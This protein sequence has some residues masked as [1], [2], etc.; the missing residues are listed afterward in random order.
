MINILGFILLSICT[1]GSIPYGGYIP[2]A[3]SGEVKLISKSEIESYSFVVTVKGHKTEKTV[4]LLRRHYD[5]EINSNTMNNYIYC[6]TNFQKQF[7]GFE[8]YFMDGKEF[9]VEEFEKRLNEEK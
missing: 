7:G 2:P 1:A 6:N 3:H 4:S 8:Y 9:S 5:W